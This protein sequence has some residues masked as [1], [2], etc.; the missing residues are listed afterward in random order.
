V[1]GSAIMA[2]G[3]FRVCLSGLGEREVFGEGDDAV[4]F[5]IEALQADPGRCR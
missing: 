3:D 2:G 1:Q 4:Q 5:G